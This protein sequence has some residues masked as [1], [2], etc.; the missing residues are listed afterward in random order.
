MAQRIKRWRV[1][2]TEP[3]RDDLRAV[4]QFIRRDNPSAA[5]RVIREVQKKTGRLAQFPLSGR[6]VPE[7]VEE[8]LRE[9]IVGNYRVIYRLSGRTVEILTVVHSQRKI[10]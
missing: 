9:V 8:G 6:V 4:F 3:A 5:Q 10:G 1:L 7:V 2:W